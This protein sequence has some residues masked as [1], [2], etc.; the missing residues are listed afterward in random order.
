MQQ[1]LLNKRAGRVTLESPKE[2]SRIAAG[3]GCEGGR[4]S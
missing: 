3:Y 1:I 2:R 4:S